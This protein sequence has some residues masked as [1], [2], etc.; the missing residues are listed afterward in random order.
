MPGRA[1]PTPSEAAVVRADGV[2]DETGRPDRDQAL[3]G[4]RP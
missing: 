4:P 3:A 2:L 1:R